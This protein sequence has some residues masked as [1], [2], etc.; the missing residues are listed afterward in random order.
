M[1]SLA[2]MSQK[3]AAVV[4]AVLA[5]GGTP[6]AF[7][8]A[9]SGGTLGSMPDL[10]F[11]QWGASERS[12][13]LGLGVSWPLSW[14][15]RWRDGPVHAYLEASVAHWGSSDRRVPGDPDKF[16]RIGVTPVVRW[17]G[18]G[19]IEAGWFVEGGIGLNVISPTYRV[20][21]RQ[22]GS[23]FNFGD[24]LAVGRRFGDGGR[25]ELA[26]RVQHFSNAGIREPNPGEDFVQLR[27]AQRF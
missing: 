10:V 7:A 1:V 4:T 22:F 3:M 20:G 5:L 2:R 18:A 26:L 12:S 14:A 15:S 25:H 21:G 17:Y 16:T 8:S 19:S 13:S 24:H 6:A 9:A 27:Y 11:A 23:R